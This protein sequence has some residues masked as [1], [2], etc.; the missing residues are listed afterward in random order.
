MD[1][2]YF[3]ILAAILYS[4]TIRYLQN[5]IID[6]NLT[7]EAQEKVKKLT[8]LHKEISKNNKQALEEFN[9]INDELFPLY[10]KILFQQL[11]FMFVILLV[12]FSFFFFVDFFDPTAKDD[13]KILL[14]KSGNEGIFLANFSIP[15]NANSGLWF[16]TVKSYNKYE[17]IASNQTYFFVESESNDSIWLQSKGENLSIYLDK[18]KYKKEEL[19]KIKVKTLPHVEKV[20]AYINNGTRLYLDLPF[21][22]PIINVRRVYDAGAIFIFYSIIISIF[23]SIALSLIEKAKLGEKHASKR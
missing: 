16:I 3:I 21:E 22:I 12:F 1:Y 9:R 20:E 2:I 19:V 11:I 8:E 6:K 23:M 15:R 4:L 17:E 7:K 18:N 5:K 13:I 10:N 14:E